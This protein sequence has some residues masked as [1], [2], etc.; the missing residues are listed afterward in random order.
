MRCAYRHGGVRVAR[1]TR[2]AASGEPSPACGAP[3]N[4]R[5]CL[6]AEY[7]VF[8]LRVG[9]RCRRAADLARRPKATDIAQTLTSHF[10]L[11]EQYHIV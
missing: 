10:F 3:R 6:C 7:L 8:L 1:G 2:G 11:I 9:G 4:T 5:R